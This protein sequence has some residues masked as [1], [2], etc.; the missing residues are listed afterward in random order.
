VRKGQYEGLKKEIETNPDRQPDFGPRK[1][2]PTAGATAVGARMPLVAYNVNL[3]TS[4]LAIAKDI[5]KKVRE[6]DGGLP[7]VKAMG[8]DIKE[9]GI[10]QVSMNLTNFH[11]TGIWKVFEEIR[12]EAKA[13]GVE[14]IGSEIVGTVPL[15]AL[16]ACSDNYLKLENFKKEQ[17]LETRLWED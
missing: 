16:V 6:K 17:I 14:V 5:A 12:K 9:R 13:R 1:M 15:E 2:H 8:F 7:S 10:V 11:V 3:N 4:D